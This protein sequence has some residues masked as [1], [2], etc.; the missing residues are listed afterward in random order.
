MQAPDTRGEFAQ[1]TNAMYQFFIECRLSRFSEAQ[2]M[3]LTST[4]LSEM[5]R[6]SEVM[7]ES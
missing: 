2:A 4:F 1:L 6:K 7:K 5:V 3:S